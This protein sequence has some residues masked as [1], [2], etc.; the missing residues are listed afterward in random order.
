MGNLELCTEGEEVGLSVGEAG[1]SVPQTPNVEAYVRYLCSVKGVGKRPNV[2]FVQYSEVSPGDKILL[3]VTNQH[4][5][6]L[7]D[8][9][10]SEL[11]RKGAKTVDVLAIDVGEDR[12][13]KYDDEIKGIIRTEGWWVNPR[14]YDYY[15]SIITYALNAGYDFLIHGRGGPFPRTNQAGQKLPF[16]FEAIPW[17]TK[18]MF[19]N[20]ATVFPPKLNELINKKTWD[21]IY[22]QGRGGKVRLTDPEGTDL[23]FTLHE[24]YFTRQ[25]E[26]KDSFSPEPVLGHMFGHPT[27]PII[28]EADTVGTVAGTTSHLSRPFPTIRLEI[29]SGRVEEVKGGAGYGDAWR[30][31]MEQT[32]DVQYPEFPRKGLFWIWEMAIGSN[33]KVKRQS[34]VLRIGSGGNEWERNRSGIIHCGF[35]TIWREKSELWAAAKG[36]PFG[37]LHV[38][39]LMGTYRVTTTRGETLTV[40]ENGRLKALDD[41]EV[42]DLAKKYGD[43]DELLKEDW[44]PRIPGISAAGLYKDYA[45][46][47]AEWIRVHG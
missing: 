16:K 43:P 46:D 45:R 30:S 4:D 37:H 10:A 21:I 38:H 12:E 34:N 42:R 39:L 7:I 13:L 5:K 28:E 19:L 22:K 6:E 47:P 18:E 2:G 1:E 40:I 25:L 29:E 17:N 8:A 35:G 27:P 31:V 36:I 11:K 9:I 20:R 24:K 3:A 32:A 14:W 44:T 33:P 23:E 15:E 26:E 41:P